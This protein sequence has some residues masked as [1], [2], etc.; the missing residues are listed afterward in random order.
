MGAVTEVYIDPS[1]AGDSGAGS[2]GDPYGDIQ[3]ALNQVT[4]DATNGDRFNIK[5]GTDEVL[6]AALDFTTYGTPTADAPW[7]CQGY[8]SAAADGGIGGISGAG[9][10]TM[11]ASAALDY[12]QLID[13]HM[14]NSGA[15]DI[16]RLNNYIT[17][18]NCEIDN[19]TSIGVWTDDGAQYINCY[20]HNCGIYGARPSTRG[21]IVM[22]CMFENG[23]NDF[24]E[25]IAP[26]EGCYVLFNVF[27]L[28]GGSSGI[29]ANSDGLLI[30]FNS[31]YSN[32]GTGR[33]IYVTTNCEQA[34]I[35]GNIF[36]GFSGVGGDGIEVLAG[37][38]VVLLGYNCFY[39]NTSNETITGD[40]WHDL[41]N[42][43]TSGSSP[44]IDAAN[45][46]FR[47]STVVRALAYLASNYPN[48][49]VRSY[50]DIGALQRQNPPAPLLRGRNT[51]LRM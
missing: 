14:H 10:Y 28:D 19:T 40:V 34:S 1:I 7:I 3:Y 24:N 22:F 41:G 9:S 2:I 44:F 32:A 18:R 23:A 8:T 36:E 16:V 43:V 13:L 37:G 4:R 31:F 42:D 33:G 25:A 12:I 20:F 17:V 49:S 15:A 6:A 45:D 21:G 47:V 5:A 26:G 29:I 27:D 39:N 46:D 50:L 38:G 48:L 11:F 35:F 30:A 51:L